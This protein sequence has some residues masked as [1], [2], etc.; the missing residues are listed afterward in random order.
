VHLQAVQQLPE[1][2]GLRVVPL[3]LEDLSDSILALFLL[4]HMRAEMQL[5]QGELEA[6]EQL[7]EMVDRVVRESLER[8]D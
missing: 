2:Q 6:L 1:V 3:L 7:V 4:I 8:P 5:R